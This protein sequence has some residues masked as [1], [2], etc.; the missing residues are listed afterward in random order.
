VGG[1]WGEAPKEIHAS[2][3]IDSMIVNVARLIVNSG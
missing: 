1:G 3:N 2:D